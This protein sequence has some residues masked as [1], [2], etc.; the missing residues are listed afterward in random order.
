[1][2]RRRRPSPSP[3][4]CAGSADR[5]TRPRPATSRPTTSCAAR[6]VAAG[7]SAANAVPAAGC[8]SPSPAGPGPLGSDRGDVPRRR[9]SSPPAPLAPLAA[10]PPRRR[11]CPGPATSAAPGRAEDHVLRR[12]RRGPGPGPRRR[13][14][15]EAHLRQHPRRPLRGHRLQRVRRARRPARARPPLPRAAWPASPARWCSRLRARSTSATL[16][17][18]AW[19]TPTRCSSPRPPATSSPSAPSTAGPLP[20][21]PGT[22]APAGGRGLRRPA[23]PRPRPL[24]SR[25]A[26][27]C[28]PR[29]GLRSPGAVAPG[30]PSREGDVGSEGAEVDD[31]ADRE[32]AALALER[33][34]PRAWPLGGESTAVARPGRRRRGPPGPGGRA[35]PTGSA[36]APTSARRA[37]GLP[38]LRAPAAVEAPGASCTSSSSRVDLDAGCRPA[39]SQATARRARGR[40]PGPRPGHVE[41]DAHHHRHPVAGGR[42]PPPRGDVEPA[43]QSAS[44]RMPASLRSARLGRPPPGRWA[45]S[46]RRA[47][48]PPP[49]PPRPRPAPPPASPGATSA[50]P[51]GAAAPTQQRRP[52]GGASRCGPDGPG[53]PS[54]GRRPARRPRPPPSPAAARRSA[55]VDPVSATHRTSAKRVSHASRT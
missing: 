44:A 1:M 5:P 21:R 15:T 28:R 8:A 51:A 27:R 55:L 39:S 11:P 48:P 52:P 23:G 17:L 49:R 18:T 35:W 2:R 37:A 43:G 50:G 22:A 6:A 12:E 16:P 53:R 10:R 30:R 13:G 54:G 46:A 14:A 33:S 34:A 29:H 40:G 25:L 38:D 42:L 32:R 7:A 20:G 31:V 47:T 19:P 45:T 41:P 26:R 36:H 9:C 3:A 4:T 24:I